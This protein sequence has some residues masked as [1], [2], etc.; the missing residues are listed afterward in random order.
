MDNRMQTESKNKPSVF[1]WLIFLPAAVLITVSHIQQRS[2]TPESK[3]SL[4][5]L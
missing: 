4:G 2:A 1:R 5:V 3:N